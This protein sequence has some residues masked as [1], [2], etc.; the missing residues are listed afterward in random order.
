MKE[1]SHGFLKK[2]QNSV[3]IGLRYDHQ[4]YFR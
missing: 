2:I 3:Q 4:E 1:V